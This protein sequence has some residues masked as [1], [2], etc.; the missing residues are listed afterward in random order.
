VTALRDAGARV[1]ITAR[2]KPESLAQPDLFIAADVSISEVCATVVQA[3]RKRL[4]VIDIH[5]SQDS[6][7]PGGRCYHLASALP[8]ATCS[9][10][11]I[12]MNIQT[13]LMAADG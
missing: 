2:P 8:P 6:C 12:P 13:T 1:L 11:N 4:R 5:N 10:P 7:L 3:V 9:T